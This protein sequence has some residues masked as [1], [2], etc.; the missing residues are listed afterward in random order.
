MRQR[1]AIRLSDAE[2]GRF[3]P[4][5]VITGEPATGTRTKTL[6]ATTPGSDWAWPL[7]LVFGLIIFVISRFV[8]TKAV[9]VDLPVSDSAGSLWLV[10]GHIDGGWLWLSGVHAEFAH[11]LGQQ[12][13]DLDEGQLPNT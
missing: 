11:A 9:S 13:A 8:S 1:A 4:I 5:C 2:K 12:Y 7:L 3:P 10:G 6:A